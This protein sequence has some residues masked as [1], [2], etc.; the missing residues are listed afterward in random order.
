M[1][2]QNQPYNDLHVRNQYATP[3]WFN[4]SC[5]K[6]YYEPVQIHTS[7]NSTHVIE[8]GRQ[9][10]VRVDKTTGQDEVVMVDYVSMNSYSQFRSSLATGLRVYGR[11]NNSPN[12]CSNNNGGCQH[13]CLPNGVNTKSCACT[14]GFQLNDDGT[15][16]SSKNWF[17]YFL[18]LFRPFM[19]RILWGV[20]KR[21]C[22][23]KWMP[24]YVL[25]QWI[26]Y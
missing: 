18:I 10:I 4:S 19:P 9:R 21:V 5:K 8:S 22:S 26:G 17:R 15:T 6:T 12:A 25:S 16:C 13:L 24:V 23:I 1:V 20:V 14:T 11:D 2:M 3:C 7:P